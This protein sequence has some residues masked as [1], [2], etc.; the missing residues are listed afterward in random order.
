MPTH[1]ALLRAVNV[2]GT[3]ILRMADLRTLCAKAGFKG[4]RTYIQSGNVVLSTARSA[5][6]TKATLERVVAKRIGKPLRVLVR[7]AEQM[8]AVEKGNPFPE[9]EPNRL[10]ILFLDDAPPKAALKGWKIPGGE[11]LALKGREL[12]VH[13]PEGQG[14]SKLKVPFMDVGTGRNLNTVRKLIAMANE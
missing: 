8:E 9:V 5:E 2:T 11:R 14:K 1:I 12:Y 10:L 6:E 4:V 7:S 3:G 13:F